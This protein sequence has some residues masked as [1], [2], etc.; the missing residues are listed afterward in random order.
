MCKDD[1]IC[2]KKKVFNTLYT[3]H[4]IHNNKQFNRPITHAL[5]EGFH[6]PSAVHVTTVVFGTNPA[7][8]TTAAED[9]TDKTLPS[10]WRPKGT[11]ICL[12]SEITIK[13]NTTHIK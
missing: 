2:A 9:P 6:V 7:S 5:G 8:Q 3:P 10:N 1:L 12:H 4:Y 11:S 13:T